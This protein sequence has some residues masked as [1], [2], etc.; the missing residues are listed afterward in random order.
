MQY[1]VY[2]RDFDVKKHIVF[3]IVFPIILIIL[4]VLL[5]FIFDLTNGPLIIFI[6]LMVGLVGFAILRTFLLNKNFIPKLLSWLGFIGFTV[7]LLSFS[8]PAEIYKSAVNF[9]NPEK[10]SVLHIDN[11]DIQGVFNKDKSVQVYAGIPYAK[12]PVGDLRRKEPQDA[13]NWDGV[14]DCSKF[15]AKCT[16]VYNNAITNTLTDIY[17]ERGWHPDLI[18]NPEAIMSEDCLY[19]N[20]WKPNTT[21]TN[22]SVMVYIHGGSLARGFSGFYAYNGETTAK[23]NVIYVTIAYRLGIFGYFASEELQNESPNHTTGNYGLL[24]QIQALKW[25][26]QNIH[27]FGGDKT[28]ITIAGESA[29]SSSVSALCTSPLA[30]GLFKRAIGESSSVVVKKAPHTF[31]ELNVAIEKGK[32]FMKEQNCTT[33]AELR[34]LPAS[35][36]VDTKFEPNE[37]TLDGYALERYPYEVYKTGDN[38]EEELLNGCNTMESDAFVIPT[39]LLSGQQQTNLSNIKERLVGEFGEKSANQMLNL[40]NLKTDDEAF[41]TFLDIISVYWF[42]YPHHSWSD[43]ATQNGVKTYKYLFS[44]Q[45]GYYKSYHSGEMVYCYGNLARDKHQYRYNESDYKLSNIMVKYR[46]NFAK[47]GNPNG[48]GIPTWDLYNKDDQKVLQLDETVE[49]IEDPYK[50]LYPIFDEFMN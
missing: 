8:K 9:D 24:D 3:C 11:G 19:L 20:V 25:V 6:I 48:E 43:L 50:D 41:R 49:K 37:M 13:E 46:T 39:Y 4:A 27:Y 44:K 42:V 30:H 34:K 10:T 18:S 31:R 33:L 38:N 36:M 47:T 7:A 1:N 23:Q 12:A 17:A 29:G 35:K 22:L 32:Q 21:E 28:N 45:N 26:N 2:M 14:L 16:Q 15:Q 40:Y 5:T